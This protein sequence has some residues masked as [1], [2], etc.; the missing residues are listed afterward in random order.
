[1]AV[2]AGVVVVT[3]LLGAAPAL[4]RGSGGN[5]DGGTGHGRNDRVEEPKDAKQ[6]KHGTRTTQPRPRPTPRST[7]PSATVGTGRSARAAPPSR[8][9]RPPTRRCA[10]AVAPATAR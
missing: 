7:P 9:R 6:A 5:G 4:A 8:G 2:V 1:V 10:G 3:F